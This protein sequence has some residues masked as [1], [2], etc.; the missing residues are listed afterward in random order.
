MVGERAPGKHQRQKHQHRDQR[1]HQRY[2]QGGYQ[3]KIYQTGNGYEQ[4]ILYRSRRQT[5]ISAAQY[6]ECEDTV[7]REQ[8]DEHSGCCCDHERMV[9]ASHSPDPGRA[10]AHS[11]DE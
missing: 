1:I 9:I 11:C 2:T 8:A 7:L 3:Q 6:I 4:C 5:A 10:D